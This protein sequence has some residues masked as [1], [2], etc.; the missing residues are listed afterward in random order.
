MERVLLTGDALVGVGPQLY[1]ISIPLPE[2][3]QTVCLGRRTPPDLELR[4]L[5]SVR[6][7]THLLLAAARANLPDSVDWYTKAAAS[8]NR[9]YLNDQY[10][11]CVI[12]GKGH[13]HGVWTGND[14]NTVSLAADK[15]IYD[16][17]QKWCGPGDNGCVITDVLD[18]MKASGFPMDDG[19]HKLDGYADCDHTNKDLVKAAI[20]LFGCLSIGINLP[21]AW[22]SAAV[23]DVTNTSIVG[24]HDVTCVGYNAQGVQVSS[25]GRIYTITWAAFANKKWIEECWALLAPDWYNKD[26]L[27]PN[28]V[29]V[30]TLRDDLTKIGGGTIPP[31]DPTPPTPPDPPTPPTPGPKQVVWLTIPNLPIVQAT[32][33]SVPYVK[34]GRYACTVETRGATEPVP[35][36]EPGGPLVF[37]IAV[38]DEPVNAFGFN[39]PGVK[40]PA[41]TLLAT[42]PGVGPTVGFGKFELDYEPADQPFDGSVSGQDALDQLEY[43]LRQEV[44]RGMNFVGQAGFGPRE[45]IVIPSWLL[46]VLRS[47]CQNIDVGDRPILKGL[48]GWLCGLLPTAGTAGEPTTITIP[49]IV[50]Q[51]LKIVCQWGPTLPL[52]P[53]YLTVLNVVCAL[54]APYLKLD[55]P[56]KKSPC[57]C[58]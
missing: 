4:K 8:I 10:G 40:V 33:K 23:W 30:A 25:W 32:S 6:L 1:G 24:G 11:D 5:R 44:A 7:Q 58:R 39:L 18:R 2:A 45:Q 41:H 31:V 15:L 16:T 46:K 51:A 56:A 47:V 26:N 14:T 49:T 28:G 50:V 42:A 19:V 22:T 55:P 35:P 54:L 13:A 34:S 52:P 57:G 3:V 53:L 17:Y 9:M 20:Y 38:P 43:L 29:S 21:S 36:P 48:L 37:T 27:A 12:A